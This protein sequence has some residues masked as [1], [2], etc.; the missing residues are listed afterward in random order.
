M[1]CRK[2][3]LKLMPLEWIAALKNVLKTLV[4]DR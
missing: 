3:T 1:L 2:L 4:Q